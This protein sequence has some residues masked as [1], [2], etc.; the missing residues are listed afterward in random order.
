[1]IKSEIKN[2]FENRFW[3][4]DNR[5]PISFEG[6]QFNILKE[7]RALKLVENF[8]EEEVKEAI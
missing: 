5:H 3:E 1:M 4:K 6:I 8:S 2:F 7:M